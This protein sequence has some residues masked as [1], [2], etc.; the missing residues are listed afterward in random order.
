MSDLDEII[1]R[2]YTQQL[3]MGV[4]FVILVSVILYLEHYTILYPHLASLFSDFGD[5]GRQCCRVFTGF[6]KVST[7]DAAALL[8]RVKANK[9]A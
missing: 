4:S 5:F 1:D 7:R 3:R 2:R 8:R 9:T 6:V